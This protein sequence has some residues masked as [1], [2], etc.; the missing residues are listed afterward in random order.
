MSGLGFAM[1]G[2]GGRGKLPVILQ[3]EAAECGLACLAMIAG[4]HGFATD[5]AWL[6]RMHAV[7]LQGATLATLIDI[8]QRLQFNVRPVRCELE[9]LRELTT[10]AILHWDMNHYV[11]LKS[12]RRDQVVVH[13]PALGERRYTLIEAS[14]HFTGIALELQPTRAFVRRDVRQR[15]QLRDFW[16][17]ATGMKRGLAHILLLSLLL[18]VFALA[19]PFYVQLVV[20]EALAR[21]DAPL[22]TVLALGF[23]LLAVVKV[24]CNALR[25]WVLLV[26]SSQL[27]LQMAGNLLRHLLALPLDWF[28]KRHLGDVLSRIGS[29]KPVR[30]LF[31]EGIVATVV[32]GA[33]ALTTLTMMLLYDAWLT[34]L[35]VLAVVLYAA[36]RLLVYPR[37][38]LLSEESLQATAREESNLM[39]TLRAMQCIKIFGKEHARHT[40]WMNR[41]VDVINNTVQLG[42]VGIAYSAA[43]GLLFGIESIAVL[44][45][46]AQQVLEHALS[47]GMLYAFISYQTQFND[48][49]AALIDRAF[50]LRMLGMHLD[51]LGDIGLTAPEQP[52]V[53]RL[54]FQPMEG[55]IT[56]RDAGFRYGESDPWILSGV[57]LE[58][59]C[60]ESL[61]LTGPSG[62]GKT[63]LLKIMMG[64]VP[65]TRGAVL[66]DDEPLQPARLADYRCICA[67]VMQDDV[68]LSGSIADNIC[69]FAPDPDMT[70]LQECA[71]LACIDADIRALPMQYATLIGDMGTALS[72]GQRQR[73][74][75]ARALYRR[76]RV[77][78][79]DE[80]T[81]HL[82]VGYARQLHANLLTLS[83][84]MVFVTHDPV[85]AAAA[86]RCLA[87]TSRQG[88]AT[89]L[90][91]ALP[92]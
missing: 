25:S 21:S 20:D 55:A 39:E 36:V 64:L 61:A 71:R 70:W 35:V 54:L 1:G 88:R 27:G 10:P 92:A 38:R 65:P 78:F 14:R 37:M 52:P 63:T 24:L 2:G 45:F 44:Y 31:S 18:Q 81:A 90:S 77:L 73:V 4:Y 87:L 9:E 89:R 3:A 29:L 85:L 26:F 84:S 19:S 15:M 12:V 11:V 6:R 86:G 66:I 30:G 47:I 46:G 50:E 69:F 13:N 51:R 76:P 91:E 42:R 80:V 34:G 32:D 62:C 22:I 57:D 58:L 56:L 75:L 60:G 67:A 68:L 82:D 53:E 28:A 41:Q 5:L 7:S 79:L 17:T 43:N 23:G 83:M 33:M 8:S 72:G 59:R 49:I 48:R 74:L 16:Q 40:L